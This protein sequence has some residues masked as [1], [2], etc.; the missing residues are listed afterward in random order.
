[1]AASTVSGILTRIGMGKLGQVRLEPAQRH[2]RARPGELIQI[3]IKELGRIERGA[4]AR[5]VG[6]AKGE[7]VLSRSCR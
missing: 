7:A 5:I 3:D 2:E 4:G 6:M 1:M